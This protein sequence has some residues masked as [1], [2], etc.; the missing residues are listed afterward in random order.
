MSVKVVSPEFCPNFAVRA[1]LGV[2]T[3]FIFKGILIPGTWRSDLRPFS[4]V[5]DGLRYRTTMKLTDTAANLAAWERL[6][7]V[8]RHAGISSTNAFAFALCLKRSE[9][10]YQ[11]KKGN[12][13]IS[14]L[15]ANRI[16]ECY[17]EINK[18]W[19][20]TGEGTMFR[21]G[22][23]SRTDTKRL[24]YIDD[25]YTADF[26]S[27]RQY[28]YISQWIVREAAY[29]ARHTGTLV[30]GIHPGDLVLLSG[31]GCIRCGELHFVEYRGKRFFCLIHFSGEEGKIML[32]DP[33][34]NNS[35]HVE[36]SAVTGQYQV[37]GKFESNLPNA[38]LQ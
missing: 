8:R 32:T 10:L 13:G 3:T 30:C 35:A 31:P 24:L 14:K 2:V 37:T 17:P 21:D 36:E 18:L 22:G 27:S 12:H 6:E 16:A 23:N 20:L 25:M 1:D 11:I 26:E 29:L 38:G 4:L 5:A 28:V 7:E 33:L 19:L 34:T 15:L 9:N